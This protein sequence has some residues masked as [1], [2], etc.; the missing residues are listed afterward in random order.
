MKLTIVTS[1]ILSLWCSIV[2]AEEDY[3]IPVKQGDTSTSIVESYL[4]GAAAWQQVKDYNQLLKP[5]NMVK[6]PSHMVNLTGKAVIS[7]VYGEVKV[8]LVGE[9]RRIT[10]IPGLIIQGGDSLETGLDSGV[11]ITMEEG[12][13]AILRGN[14]SVVFNPPDAKTKSATTLLNVL[15]GK[16][17]SFINKSPNRDLRYRIQTP[18]AVSLVRGTKFRTK[19]GDN[20]ETIFEVLEGVVNVQSDG[21]ELNLDGDFGIKI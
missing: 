16:V 5:G 8:K 3:A 21:K 11:E 2:I 20:A 19:V 17:I 9:E 1:L 12:D 15:R 6:V 10:A 4:T 13:R 7:L 18:T 14:T